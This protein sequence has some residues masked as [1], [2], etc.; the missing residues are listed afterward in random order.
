MDP[1]FVAD[2]EE[3]AATDFEPLDVEDEE[4][5]PEDEA[6][7]GEAEEP[8]VLFDADE[9]T[10]AVDQVSGAVS[11][12]VSETPH[13]PEPAAEDAAVEDAFATTRSWPPPCRRRC[14]PWRCLRNRK[15]GRTPSASPIS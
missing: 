5:V 10:A 6:A 13:E 11:G 2:L 15:T 14:R 12:A 3:T 4:A 8:I 9:E 7:E 1:A